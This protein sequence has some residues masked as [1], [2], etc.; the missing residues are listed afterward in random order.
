MSASSTMLVLRPQPEMI[1]ERMA[2]AGFLAGYNGSTRVGYSTDLRLRP[3]APFRSGQ[4][5]KRCRPS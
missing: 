4:R 1:A 3:S 2:V 5:V